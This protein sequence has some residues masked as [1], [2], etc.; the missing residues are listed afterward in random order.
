MIDANRIIARMP[1]HSTRRLGLV[2]I[3]LDRY[4]EYTGST[5]EW[6][7]IAVRDRAIIRLKRTSSGPWVISRSCA[8]TIPQLLL[9]RFVTA[10]LR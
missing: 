6:L 3:D 5:V 7:N 1:N 10:S 4:G 9:V 2:S 8:D